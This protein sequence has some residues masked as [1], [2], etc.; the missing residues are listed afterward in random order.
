MENVFPWCEKNLRERSE[1][2]GTSGYGRT[3]VPRLL[4][5]NRA[6]HVWRMVFTIEWVRSRE[7]HLERDG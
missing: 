7:V 1:D 6:G 5:E 3:N 4:D 2:G